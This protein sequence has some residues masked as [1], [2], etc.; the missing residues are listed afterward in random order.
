MATMHQLCKPLTSDLVAVPHQVVDRDGLPAY[1]YSYSCAVQESQR[2][3]RIP[4]FHAM[5]AL[6]A[7]RRCELYTVHGPGTAAP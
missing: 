4:S 3:P 6:Y 5:G 2:M 7:E 1:S